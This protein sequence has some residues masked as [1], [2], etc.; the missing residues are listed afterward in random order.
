[1]QSDVTWGP[2]YMSSL[3]HFRYLAMPSCGVRPLGD[4][5]RRTRY[6][7]SSLPRPAVDAVAMEITVTRRQQ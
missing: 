4:A 2:E 1:M 3:G 7:A 5:G 6:A